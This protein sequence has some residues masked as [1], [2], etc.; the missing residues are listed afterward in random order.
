MC[1]DGYC[2]ESI[3][4]MEAIV[5][6]YGKPLLRPAFDAALLHSHL[7]SI[8]KILELDN[9]I[10]DAGFS[11]VESYIG[12]KLIAS[13]ATKSEDSSEDDAS[14]GDDGPPV[15]LVLDFFFICADMSKDKIRKI[16]LNCFQSQSAVDFNAVA[17]LLVK[18][19][20][21]Y[22][23][24]VTRDMLEAYIL[25]KAIQFDDKPDRTQVHWL[26]LL[27]DLYKC[28]V[29]SGDEGVEGDYNDKIISYLELK[30]KEFGSFIKY[31]GDE[32]AGVAEDSRIEQ[33][34]LL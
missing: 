7:A 5:Q 29:N 6:A 26:Q 13:K 18:S 3:E 25:T 2:R 32:E 8:Q 19:T 4:A 14:E 21:K 34:E 22:N 17:Q 16:L 23:D 12:N 33:S 20:A 24:L 11:L 9:T 27:L 31:D 30:P 15:E 28:A 1:D 10:P